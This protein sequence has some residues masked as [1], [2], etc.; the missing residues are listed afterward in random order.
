MDTHIPALLLH[1]GLICSAITSDCFLL[2][3]VVNDF[4]RVSSKNYYRYV[5]GGHVTFVTRFRCSTMSIV[6]NQLLSVDYVY[7]L[8]PL[9]AIQI[10]EWLPITYLTANHSRNVLRLFRRTIRDLNGCPI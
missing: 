1:V 7:L 10:I 2:F 8:W 6:Y 9:L 3:S 4:T 5:L